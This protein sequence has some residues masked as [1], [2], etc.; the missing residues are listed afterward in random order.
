MKIFNKQPPIMS[1]MLDLD[2]STMMHLLPWDMSLTRM[3]RKEQITLQGKNKDLCKPDEAR[4]Y[5]MGW[6]II[7]CVDSYYMM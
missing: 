4:D 7:K 1:Q 5:W 6:N 2:S 3:N